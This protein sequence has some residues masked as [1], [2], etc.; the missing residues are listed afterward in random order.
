MVPQVVQLFVQFLERDVAGVARDADVDG[1]DPVAEA[2]AQIDRSCSV[3]R[4]KPRRMICA[5]PETVLDGL[6]FG[7]ATQGE[8]ARLWRPRGAVREQEDED[9]QGHG[10]RQPG[11]RLPRRSSGQF[12]RLL[13]ECM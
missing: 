10:A 5:L 12:V 3:E 2:C 13:C 7:T 11:E 9:A 8:A 6:F 1:V 4:V